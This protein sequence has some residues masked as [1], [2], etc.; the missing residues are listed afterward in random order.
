MFQREAYTITQIYERM[1]TF[2]FGERSGNGNPNLQGITFFFF[3]LPRI[4]DF[5]G[6][7]NAY[8][9]GC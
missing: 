5:V 1:V 8:L 2:M 3:F 9:L 4:L 7:Y 6:I